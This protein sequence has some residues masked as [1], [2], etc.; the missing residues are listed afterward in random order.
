MVVGALTTGGASMMTGSATG[1]EGKYH[2]STHKESSI[3]I[4][5]NLHTK[6]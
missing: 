5:A 4:V 1:G 2:I 6:I 3:P